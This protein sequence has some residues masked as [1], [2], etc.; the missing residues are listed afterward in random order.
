MA[1]YSFSFVEEVFLIF[2]TK[3]MIE[4]KMYT[5]ESVTSGHPEKIC[6]Q[7][8]D[9]ILDAYLTRDPDSRVAV[10]CFGAH[11][12][13]TVGGEVM[14]SAKVDISQIVHQVYNDIGY[15]NA[16]DVT[17]HMISQSPDIARGV[18]KG[19][20]GDQGIMYGYATDETPEYLPRGVVLA[21]KL[22][23]GLEELR[24]SGEL[25]WLRPDGKTQVTMCEG[26]VHT[27][28]VSTQ[29]D[30]N[31]TNA[32]ICN[33]ITKKLI[34]PIVGTDNTISAI[35][36]N[37]TGRF[38][39]GG[40]TA[41]TGLTGRKIMVDTYGGLIPHG[42][43]CFS[44]KD[45]TKVDRSG[46]YMARFV[47]KNLVAHGYAKRCLVSIAYAIGVVEPVM[48]SA[49]NERGEQLSTIVTR[50]FDLTPRGIM[51]RLHLHR[52]VFRLTG[53]YGHFGTPSFSWEDIMDHL[54]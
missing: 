36:I 2:K 54:T 24:V 46:A 19:G 16:L 47:A 42:G 43:G 50:N 31:V 18:D 28:V 51:E 35:Y 1:I 25:P 14:S 15:D 34:T 12:T 40:F 52:P 33:M 3:K 39:V 9:A 10:E 8:S 5:V 37:P 17:E 32:E 22:A 38:V 21:H 53:A 13:V 11:G 30:E 41:D 49:V 7:M 26:R 6:D 20:A 29:H 27:I 4:Q 48:V 23:R 44:G 45:G